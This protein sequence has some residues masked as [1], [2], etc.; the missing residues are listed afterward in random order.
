MSICLCIGTS[1]I[2]SGSFSAPMA[3]MTVPP[4]ETPYVVQPHALG[5]QLCLMGL[6]RRKDLNH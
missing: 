4:T 5:H 2:L 6:L 1:Q 3:V